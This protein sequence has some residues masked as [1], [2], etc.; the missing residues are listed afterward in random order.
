[1]SISYP[2]AL[3]SD[4]DSGSH[5]ENVERQSGAGF[6]FNPERKW[7]WK[8]ARRLEDFSLSSAPAQAFR[9]FSTHQRSWL[10]TSLSIREA[11][12]GDATYGTLSAWK[13]NR[14]NK[15]LAVGCD[16]RPPG[17]YGSIGIRTMHLRHFKPRSSPEPEGFF[18]AFLEKQFCGA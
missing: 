1:M 16:N 18:H 6:P 2:I 7:L 13:L 4:V 11:W 14:I 8:F 3:S 10:R 12:P 15:E 5:Q 9:K 17:K